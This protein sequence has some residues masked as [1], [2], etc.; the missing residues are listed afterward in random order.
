[1]NDTLI[2]SANNTDNLLKLVDDW[3]DNIHKEDDMNIDSY[4][5]NYNRRILFNTSYF[6]NIEHMFYKYIFN[7]SDRFQSVVKKDLEDYLKKKT[8]ELYIV[9]ILM[10][11]LTSLFCLIKAS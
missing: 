8:V 5:E 7:V 11:V 9:G 2:M 4:G 10:G 3:V 6:K 1:M